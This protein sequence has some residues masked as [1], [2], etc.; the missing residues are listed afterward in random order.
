MQRNNGDKITMGRVKGT[1]I[2]RLGKKLVEKYPGQFGINF[3]KNKQMLHAMGLKMDSKIELNKL[4]G[5]ITVRT[6]KRLA[7]QAPDEDES[8]E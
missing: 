6:K 5:E 2:K 3:T 1:N 8:T 4:A 7:K